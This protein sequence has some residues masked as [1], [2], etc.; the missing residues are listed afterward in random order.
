MAEAEERRGCSHLEELR[1][2]AGGLGVHRTGCEKG[3]HRVLVQESHR[4]DSVAREAHRMDF[5]V[6]GAHRM[7][8][9][10]MAH[11]K[12]MARVVHRKQTVQVVRRTETEQAAVHR[13]AIVHGMVEHRSGLKAEDQK[14]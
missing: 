3:H 5:V 9:A 13:K 2:T 11:H 12:E 10:Q 4:K 7:E 8:M 6:Q 1:K 14:A